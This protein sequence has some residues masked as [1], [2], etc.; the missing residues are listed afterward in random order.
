MSKSP[1]KALWAISVQ[2]NE[3]N[4]VSEQNQMDPALK[5]VDYNLHGAL[6]DIE[7]QDSD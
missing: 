1:L 7:L 3:L 4:Y 2:V 6:S 5:V